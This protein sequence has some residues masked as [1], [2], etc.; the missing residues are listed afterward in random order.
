MRVL[1]TNLITGTCGA[2]DTNSGM[3]MRALSPHYNR[4]RCA[5]VMRKFVQTG[6][7]PSSINIG[8]YD[9]TISTV[10]GVCTDQVW[11]VTGCARMIR[12]YRR[13]RHISDNNFIF[14]LFISVGGV[15]CGDYDGTCLSYLHQTTSK[16]SNYDQGLS[17]DTVIGMNRLTAST[18]NFW[19]FFSPTN[20]ATIMTKFRSDTM[21]MGLFFLEERFDINALTRFYS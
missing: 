6:I 7:M 21:G 8:C 5:F 14:S 19:V 15:Y 9:T 20:I 2:R 16:D 13:H 17:N 12:L 10:V 4:M 11:F 1:T 18:R 3:L